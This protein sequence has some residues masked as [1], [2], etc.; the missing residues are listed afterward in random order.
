MQPTLANILGYHPVAGLRLPTI[1]RFSEFSPIQV[2]FG[3]YTGVFRHTLYI[4]IYITIN[5]IIAIVPHIYHNPYVMNQLKERSLGRRGCTFYQ[6][7]V[8]ECSSATMR[9]WPIR[10]SNSCCT[11][12][13]GTGDVEIGSQPATLWF[14]DERTCFD[15]CVR[16]TR[17]SVF[18]NFQHSLTMFGS[19]GKRLSN[20]KFISEL[21]MVKS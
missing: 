20:C 14:D 1:Q 5:H 16:L 10:T 8:Q 21:F 6:G 4:Y 13:C 7:H 17:F 3:R 12:P 19:S 11:L 9:C 18:A 2:P 15:I